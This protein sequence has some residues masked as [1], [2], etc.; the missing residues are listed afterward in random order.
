MHF[1]EDSEITSQIN[2]GENINAA[3]D[4]FLKA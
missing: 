3:F 2:V 4:E 1:A